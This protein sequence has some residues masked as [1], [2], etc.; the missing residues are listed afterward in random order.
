MIIY[1][2]E[3]FINICNE[4]KS[5]LEAR[6][7]IDIHWR[8]FRK[9]AIKLNCFKPNQGNINKN[10][11]NSYKLEDILN[12]K[13]P[14]YQ[15]YKLKNRLIKEGLKT[16]ICELCGITNW[17]NKPIICHLHHI[18]GNHY[19]N[20][21]ENLQML[22]PNCHS[23]T[24]TY[25]S[26]NLKI[27]NEKHK[28]NKMLI[29]ELNKKNKYELN[30]IEQKEKIE[31]LLNSDID[32]SKFGWVNKASKILNIRPQKVNNWMKKNMLEFYEKNCF[33]RTVL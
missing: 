6:S 19:N 7:K 18:D 10:Y 23:Q 27:K 13:Y 30:K 17:N 32:F 16:N 29:D 31:L 21:I 20:S 25:M 12:G 22:C 9:R 2:D 26:K 24:E 14:H 1:T 28:Y 5:M 33:K 3:E 15:S 11:P 8:T 4:S